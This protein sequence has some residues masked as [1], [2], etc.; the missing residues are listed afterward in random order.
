M[1]PQ[2]GDGFVGEGVVFAR[3]RAEANSVGDS[4]GT[5]EGILIVWGG[6]DVVLSI[7]AFDGWQ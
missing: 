7:W 6:S 3:G 2:A 1:M 5:E 4:G